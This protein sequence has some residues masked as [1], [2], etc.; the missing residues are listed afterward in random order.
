MM[1]DWMTRAGKYFNLLCLFS[2]AIIFW[3]FTPMGNDFR[4]GQYFHLMSMEPGSSPVKFATGFG[5]VKDPAS[6]TLADSAKF[7]FL[8][9]SLGLDSL[10]LSQK[11]YQEAVQ[12]YIT[13][14]MAGE[15]RNPA[16]LSI[17]DFSLPSSKK[18]LFVLDM[19]NGRL[20]F[21]T[22]VSHGRNSGQLMATRFSNRN[23]SYMSSIGFYLTGDA[24]IGE[25]GYS[26]RLIG[27]EK[28]LNDNVYR[29]SIVMHPADYVSEEHIRETGY[30]GRS[31]GCPAIPNGLNKPIIGKIR[32]GSCL[33]VFSPDRRIVRK[34][35]ILS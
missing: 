33:Y 29:R 34:S 31:E 9:D 6:L 3:D 2:A 28:G 24:Y 32:G 8:Y 5:S 12:G 20:L 25:H 15:I 35:R 21:N 23:N 13:M 26:L 30:L 22:L 19:L 10:N 27:E 7:N 4:T 14:Q 17:I 11:A 16:V 18:R 1:R